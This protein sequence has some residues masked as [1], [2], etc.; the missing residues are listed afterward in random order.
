MKEPAW[1]E[2]A[3][4]D[5]READ[6]KDL[7]D[8]AEIELDTSISKGQR[9]KYLTEKLKNPYCFKVG[10]IAVKLEFSQNAPALQTCLTDFLNRK[11]LRFDA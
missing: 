7:T 3:G 6:K 4:T 11:K 8:I 2:L 1:S 10:D 5:I 9:G